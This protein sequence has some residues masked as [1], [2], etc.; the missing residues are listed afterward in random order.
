MKSPGL[1]LTNLAYHYTPEIEQ[2]AVRGRAN[3]SPNIV[4]KKIIKS[5]TSK[6]LVIG[7]ML[8]CTSVFA[9]VDGKS[10]AQLFND[11][12]IKLVSKTELS[13]EQYT[14][15]L[16]FDF[17]GYRMEEES[18]IIKVTGGPHLELYSKHRLESGELDA[19]KED[20][21]HNEPKTDLG[22]VKHEHIA[23]ADKKIKK[24]QIRVV[25]V[26]GSTTN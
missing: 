6:L 5:M 22:D 7:F 12:G 8:C 14:Q 23:P 15:L 9:Q 20:H 2:S 16:N 10:Y 4:T 11:K 21:L 26:F 1:F 24:L 17:E 13:S 25:D 18:V 3:V 19:T